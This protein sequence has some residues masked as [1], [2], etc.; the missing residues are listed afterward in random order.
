MVI[1]PFV[2][3][4][5][6]HHGFV[7]KFWSHVGHVWIVDLLDFQAGKQESTLENIAQ[8]C[9]VVI[10]LT[11]MRFWYQNP[12]KQIILVNRKQAPS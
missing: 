9:F 2:S 12:L 6:V 7:Q 3:A 1:L 8:L 4:F 10:L 11:S 5:L